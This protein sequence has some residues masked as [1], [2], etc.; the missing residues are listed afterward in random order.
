MK[1]ELRAFE[2]KR[3]DNI[4]E[5]FDFPKTFDNLDLDH[6]IPFYARIEKWESDNDIMRNFASFKKG[7]IIRILFSF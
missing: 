6:L 5:I 3:N 1:E 7:N 4:G 2:A